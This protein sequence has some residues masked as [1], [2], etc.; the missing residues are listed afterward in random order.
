MKLITFLT[1]ILN[2]FLGPLPSSDL[3]S[4]PSATITKT[5]YKEIKVNDIGYA[6]AL[7]GPISPKDIELMTNLPKKLPSQELKDAHQC[8][9]LINGGFYGKNDQPLGLFLTEGVVRHPQIQSALFNG[10]FAKTV[11]NAV[12]INNTLPDTE[13]A[14]ALQSG[15]QL[16]EDGIPRVLKMKEDEHA[17][18]MIVATTPNGAVYFFSVFLPNN[19]FSGPQLG[20]LPIIME[21]IAKKESI[22]ATEMLNLDGGNHSAFYNHE[23]IISE[24]SPIGSFFC[25][26]DK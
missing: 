26:I 20:D 14:F 6:Y 2:L 17:R 3:T 5:P 21:A 25:I 13:L 22:E 4:T 9:Y 16:T 18:R 19:T 7:I 15:P 11:N 24:L 1:A 12:S 8:R 23:A 10:L